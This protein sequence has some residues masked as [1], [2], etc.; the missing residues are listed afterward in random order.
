[1]TRLSAGAAAL[2]RRQQAGATTGAALT[3]TRVGGATVDLT[4]KAWPGRS[5]PR[6]NPVPDVRGGAVVVSDRDFLIPVA[7]LATAGTP[8]QPARGDRLTDATG[9]A[10][11][12]YEVIAP[13]GEKEWRFTDQTNTVYRV[14]CKR[15][16]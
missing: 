11:T 7:D 16:A 4:G 14:H 3:Y 12:V 10:A 15:V 2:I 8:F 5:A 9:G 6:R 1:M 13:T